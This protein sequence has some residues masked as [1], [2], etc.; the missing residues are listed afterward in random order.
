[1]INFEDF[2]KKIKDF[3]DEV[4]NILKKDKNTTYGS[5]LYFDIKEDHIN[6]VGDGELQGQ[7]YWSDGKFVPKEGWDG[8]WFYDFK[9]MGIEEAFDKIKKAIIESI[10]GR[11]LNIIGDSISK[12]AAIAIIEQIKRV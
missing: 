12:Q 9:G 1:M 6:A 10:E 4:D 8:H 11:N 5:A 3:Q 7:L 2:K